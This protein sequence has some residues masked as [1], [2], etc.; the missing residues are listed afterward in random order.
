MKDYC[1]LSFSRYSFVSNI[2]FVKHL[3]P[4][5]DALVSNCY[6][7]YATSATKLFYDFFN[8]NGQRMCIN[9]VKSDDITLSYTINSL[10]ASSHT[11]SVTTHDQTEHTAAGHHWRSATLSTDNTTCLYDITVE[12]TVSITVQ[13]CFSFQ[14]IKVYRINDLPA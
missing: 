12:Y 6:N 14:H 3:F 4:L 8:S 11:L 7:I 9:N 13:H 10:S 2:A 5:N 1:I